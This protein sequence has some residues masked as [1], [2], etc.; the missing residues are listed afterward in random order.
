MNSESI[1][2]YAVGDMS[3]GDFPFCVGYGVRSATNKFGEKYIFKNIKKQFED[4]DFVFGNLETTISN[5][6]FDNNNLRSL[7]M[8]G[9]PR[10]INEL[11]DNKFKII[12]LANN[13]SMQHGDD[14]FTDTVNLLKKSGIE[15]VGIIGN[16]KWSSFPVKVEKNGIKIGFLGY[17]FETDKYTKEQKKYA[18]GI[19]SNIKTDIE[20]LRSEVDYLI[21][22]YHW[23]LEF[24]DR[25]SVSNIRLAHQTI[26]YGADIILGHHPH[27]LQGIERYKNGIIFYSLGNFVFDM[28]WNKRFQQSMLVKLKLSSTKK[29]TYEVIPVIINNNYQPSIAIGDEKQKITNTLKQ[30]SKKIVDEINGDTEFNSY[31][32]YLEYEKLRKINRYRCYIY[33]FRNINRYNKTIL[34]QIVKRTLLRRVDDIKNILSLKRS[35]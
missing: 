3:F 7:E 23:G 17:A 15:C 25:P 24:M 14:A 10:V 22:S 9:D 34:Y 4:G 30:I 18:Y 6:N 2:L 28:N 35:K 32:Y 26:E 8:R 13:H 1:K 5:H 29:I 21:V 12:N 16:N 31:K 20:R 33:F 11:V 19:P 27:V